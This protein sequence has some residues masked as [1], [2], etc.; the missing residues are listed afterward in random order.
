MGIQS[1][2]ESILETIIEAANYNNRIASLML[3]MLEVRGLRG[4]AKELERMA[5]LLLQRAVKI[6]RLINL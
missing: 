3:S 6:N 1:Q 2:N 5:G 4:K